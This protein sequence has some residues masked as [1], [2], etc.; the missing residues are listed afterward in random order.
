[1]VHHVS[2][3]SLVRLGFEMAPLQIALVDDNKEYLAPYREALNRQKRFE[4]TDIYTDYRQLI[5]GNKIHH[6]D[7]VITDM[8]MQRPDSG[9]QLIRQLKAL[10]SKAKVVVL[11]DFFTRENLIDCLALG[12]DAYLEK[13]ITPPNLADAIQVVCNGGMVISPGSL[14]E[15]VDYIKPAINLGVRAYDFTEEDRVLIRQFLS[16]K[17]YQQ[18]ASEMGISLSTVKRRMSSVAKQV[19]ARNRADLFAKLSN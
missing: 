6:I 8:R 10:G 11:T 17:T 4:A 1:M 5:S 2:T 18:I 19:G 7:V 14:R 9:L 15:L 3:Q 13:S 16:G 12:I